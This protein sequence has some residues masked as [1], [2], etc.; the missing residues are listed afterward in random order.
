MV[1][2][3]GFDTL[4]TSFDGVTTAPHFDRTAYRARITFATIRA[5]FV[6]HSTRAD[7]SANLKLDPGVQEL[8][9]RKFPD[10]FVPVPGGWGRQGWTTVSLAHVDKKALTYCLQVAY[11]LASAKKKVPKARSRS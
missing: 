7:A 10:A 3:K 8:Y 6:A 11:G 4:A 5:A 2:R 9:C 1:T